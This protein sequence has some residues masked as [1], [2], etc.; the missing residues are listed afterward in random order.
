L[1]EAFESPAAAR[2]PYPFQG[3]LVRVLREAALAQGRL[4]L[5]PFW[6]GQSAALIR[7]TR[8]SELFDSLVLDAASVST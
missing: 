4:D 8:A 3:H 6:S 7:H 5:V 2:L 1:A